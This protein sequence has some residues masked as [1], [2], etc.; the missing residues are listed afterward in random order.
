MKIT[1]K[2]IIEDVEISWYRDNGLLGFFFYWKDKRYCNE[3]I[4]RGRLP[5]EAFT[6]DIIKDY[7]NWAKINK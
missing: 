6:D 5:E 7:I 4:P 3:V 2:K 1:S